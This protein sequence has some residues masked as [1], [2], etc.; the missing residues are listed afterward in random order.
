MVQTTLSRNG[1]K[2][3]KCELS[4]KE[5]K[6]IKDDLTVNPYVVGDF[7]NGNEKRFSLYMESPNSLYLPR[8]Y[9]FDNFGSP[10]KNKIDEGLD[11][12]I[13]F[14]GL[15]RKEQ[16]PIID[17]Y[18]KACLEKG[19]GLI[20]L[21]CGGGKTVL[22]LYIISMLKKK[23]IVIVH[24]DFLM[25]QWRDRI[26]EFLPNARIGKIQQNTIDIEN[27]D[28]V[29]AMVQS[30]SQKEYD[31]NVFS[32]FGLA[33]FDECH[34][35]GAEVFSKSMSKVASK[36]MLG[37]SATPDRKDG[38]RKVFEWYIGPMV[39]SSKS[40]KN[41]DYIETR[42]YEYM[43]DD[44]QYS[45]IDKIHTKN[46]PKPCMPRMINNISDCIHR[47][48]FINDLIKTEYNI[49]RKIL[50]LGDRREYLNRTEK[51]I[52][53]NIDP[54]IVGQYVGGMKPSELRDSQEKDIILG[55][56]SMA[57]EGM[58]IPKLN[59]IVLASPK[60]D[61]VQSVGR[62]LREKADVRKFHPLIIDFS[63]IHPNLS[64]FSKQCDKRIS[65]YKKNN[66]EIHVYKMDGSKEKL[67]KRKSKKKK[68][69]HEIKECLILD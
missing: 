44:Y 64:V 45:K 20:S 61:V 24:K 68:E 25:T 53:E 48:L 7:G 55:T 30:L 33:V 54:N 4:Q 6:S 52:K 15:L 40:D 17:L 31:P 39:Y 37:L 43:N 10:D 51:W 50:V 38:L 26:T 28:I 13:N 42:I 65:F 35:L 56:Y 9:A 23:T 69:I 27:K 57:S 18:K 63:D 49:G 16:I 36:Y 34:H 29:L 67:E 14:N 47:N 12:D 19:G 62:I 41:I 46:G 58:D 8:F 59:T 3:K 2:I 21:K 60:S 11:I 66:Y 32:S 5:L 22:A 1:Y